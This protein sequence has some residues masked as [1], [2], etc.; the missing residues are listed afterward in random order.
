[1]YSLF[2]AR[3]AWSVN[4]PLLVHLPPFPGQ[5]NMPRLPPFLQDR[6]VAS[7]NY[8]WSPYS[9][10]S[11]N[12]NGSTPLHWPTPI[13]D[14]AFAMTWLLENLS[15]PENSRR[16]IYVY[17]S[18]LGASLATS[19]ALTEAHTHAR[20]GV[21]GLIAYNGI[22]NWTMFLPDH[23]INRV[24]KRTST[25]TPPREPIK[26]SRLHEI[27]ENVPALFD[28]A[29]NLFDPFASPSLFFHSPGLEVPESFF[30]TL[31]QATLIDNM[32]SDEEIPPTPIK[33]PRK[34]YLMFPPKQS[35]LKI[36][37]TLIVYESAPSSAAV[38]T[39]GKSKATTT[40]KH[41][42]SSGHSFNSQA[43]EFVELMRRSVAEAELREGAKWDEDLDEDLDYLTEEATR[44]VQMFDAGSETESI[45]PDA[46][47]SDAIS[48]WIEERL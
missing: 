32:T 26:S 14:T 34:T 29:S 37:E 27:Q 41:T 16:D 22:Y 36:P 5:N 8:R 28:T 33:A 9:E 4:D 1:M 17:G 48:S 23:E 18:Y 15:P 46:A 11:V 13:H 45:E 10:P 3:D 2:N 19:L 21:R 30:M 43:A 35:T 25:V 6:P 38:K 7:I 40:R 44:R 20:F 31:E 42:K 12:S 39:T 24:S 47:G